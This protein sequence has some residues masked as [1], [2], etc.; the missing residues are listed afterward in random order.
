MLD[1]YIVEEADIDSYKNWQHG[2]DDFIWKNTDIAKKLSTIHV[3]K[4]IVKRRWP[5]SVFMED[6][7]EENICFSSWRNDIIKYL[8]SIKKENPNK[9]YRIVGF[10]HDSIWNFWT[11]CIWQDGYVCSYDTVSNIEYIEKEE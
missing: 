4:N 5:F 2:I 9:V 8:L 10:Y 3:T 7:E 1:N 6:K 11:V